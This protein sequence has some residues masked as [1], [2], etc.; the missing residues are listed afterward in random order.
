VI[1]VVLTCGAGLYRRFRSV[2]VPAVRAA[3]PSP[4]RAAKPKPPVVS[5]VDRVRNGTLPEFEST[6]VGQAF[7][8]TFQ[9]PE[10]KAGLNLQGENVV[11]FHGT[12]TYAA[13][14]EA[15]FYVG[16]WNGVSQG[17]EA[18]KQVADAKQRCGQSDDLPVSP[19]LAKAYGE[20]AIPVAFEFVPLPGGRIEM[21]SVDPVFQTFDRDH[22]LRRDRN[23]MLA[24]IFR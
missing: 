16:T 1:A 10:W 21:T 24:F 17:I 11:T 22:R 5:P 23:A 15:G 6:A 2:K 20:I 18:A 19:C 8:K 13:M 3:A 14:K 7:E 12:A 4:A 9:T